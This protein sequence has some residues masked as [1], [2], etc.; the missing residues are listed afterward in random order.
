MELQDINNFAQTSNEDQHKAFGFLGQGM[1][2]NIPKYCT[3][4]SKCSPRTVNLQRHP[5]EHFRW[6]DGSFRDSNLDKQSE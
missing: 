1:A 2:E 5:A 4:A 3:C 6:L